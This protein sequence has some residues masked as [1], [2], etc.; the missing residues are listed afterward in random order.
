MLTATKRPLDALDKD[1]VVRVQPSTKRNGLPDQHAM[2]LDSVMPA[3]PMGPLPT[4]LI[5]YPTP[6]FS[7]PLWNPVTA[8]L[9]TVTNQQLQGKTL[10]LVFYPYNF[11]EQSVGTLTAYHGICEKLASRNAVVV[12]CS[13]DSH[14]SH[15][16][17]TSVGKDHRGIAG[18]SI[19]LASDFLKTATRAFHLLDSCTGVAERATVVIDASQ[20]IRAVIKADAESIQWELREVEKTR[21]EYLETTE[22][23]ARQCWQ[24]LLRRDDMM[25][26][27]FDN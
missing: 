17:W 7:L 21:N 8:T 18:L 24:V 27:Q 19:P 20:M 23:R 22:F 11:N 15:Q 12:G 25:L 16:A 13:T 5:S 9:T 26:V 4:P 3:Y 6:P 14:H 2:A 1:D 10:V